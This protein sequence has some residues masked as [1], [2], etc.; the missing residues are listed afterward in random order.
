[1]VTD[2]KGC[3]KSLSAT[4]GVSSPTTSTFYRDADS[5]GY[6]DAATSTTGTTAPEGYVANNTDCND[7]DA[8]VHPGATE[9]CDGK[10]NNCDGVVDPAASNVE[11]SPKYPDGW[12]INRDLKMSQYDNPGNMYALDT[13][14][15]TPAIYLSTPSAGLHN[16]TTPAM[17]FGSGTT[18]INFNFSAFAFDADTRAFNCRAMPRPSFKCPVSYRV[19]LVP[20]SYTSGAI[21][22]S[23]NVLGQSDWKLIGYG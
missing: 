1:M 15:I 5:D 19:Y 11:A 12:I 23:A 6:G 14:L 17:S 18:S 4:V 16:V 7:A 21:P 3:T 8:A 13:G 9:V 2:A 22:S 10:D 20:A